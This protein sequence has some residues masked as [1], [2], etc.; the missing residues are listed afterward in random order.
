MSILV[1]VFHG[2]RRSG[3]LGRSVGGGEGLRACPSQ[4]STARPP[5]VLTRRLSCTTASRRSSTTSQT[6]TSTST[7]SRSASGS[8]PTGRARRS[9]PSP[10]KT[11]TRDKF[12]VPHVHSTTYDGGYLG[13]RLARGRGS[14]PALQQARFNGRVAAIDA[15]GL[16]AIS[17]IAGLKKL[18]AERP[19]EGRDLKA[20]PGPPS[21]LARREWP[22]FTTST[23]LSPGS[24]TTWRSTAPPRRPGRG[25]TSMH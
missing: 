12:D 13:G 17:L 14:R 10:G 6:P 3:R 16:N 25:T 21:R 9:S 11:I 19:D 15:P 2:G 5:R 20:D 18:P 23:R 4:G 24:M 7:S 1:R 8:T 22:C